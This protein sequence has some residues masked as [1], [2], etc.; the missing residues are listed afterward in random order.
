MSHDQLQ[1]ENLSPLVRLERLNLSGNRIQRI[2]ESIVELQSLQMLRL[3]RNQLNVVDDLVYLGEIPSLLRLRIEDNPI[4][5]LSHTS[6][7]AILSIQTLETLDGR[8]VTMADR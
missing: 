6:A 3:A 5:D 1:I 2:P 4:S 7:V 8:E